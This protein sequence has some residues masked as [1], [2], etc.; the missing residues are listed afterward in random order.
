MTRTI[1]ADLLAEQKKVT[2]TPSLAM[3]IADNG[4]P[5][6][7]AH[8]SPTASGATQTTAAIVTDTAII[9]IQRKNGKLQAQRI[10]DP[11][12]LS[13][14]NSW[15][16]IP[17]T[18]D[19]FYPA[20]F[21]TGS[22]VVLVYQNR[23]TGADDKKVYWRTSATGSSWNTAAYLWTPA[24]YLNGLQVG[25]SGGSSWS[26]FFYVDGTPGVSDTKVAFRRYTGSGFAAADISGDIGAGI[27]GLGATLKTA[28]EYVVVVST[29]SYVS[30]A[31]NSLVALTFDGDLG[32]YITLG[33]F[34]DLQG[35][36]ASSPAY[37]ATKLNLYLRD[38]RYWLS[39]LMEV[40]QSKGAFLQKGDF[41]LTT[42]ET[43][44]YPAAGIKLGD[45]TRIGGEAVGDCVR[46]LY[47]PASG[48]TYLAADGV[49]LKSTPIAALSAD[50]TD[51]IQYRLEDDGPAGQLEIT[52]DNRTGSFD[53]L[54]TGRLGAD[55]TLSRGAVIN[56]TARRVSREKF[57]V[58]QIVWS[59]DNSR[60]TVRGYN[61]YRLL[62]LWRAEWDYYWQSQT[63]RGLV[64]ILTGLAGLTD[65]TFDA[66]FS[67]WST[68]VDEFSLQA[69]QSALNG[70]EILMSQF[71]F[72]ARMDETNRLACL[73]LSDS[74]TALYT[75]G[76]AGG[77][78]PTLFVQD[79]SERTLPDT[80]HALVLGDEVGGEALASAIQ[81]E[82][83]RRFT[84]FASRRY[85][86]TNSMAAATAGAIITKVEQSVKQARLICLPAFHLEPF[87]AVQA[88][89][90]ETD[91]IHYL[92]NLQEVYNT[93]GSV[94][95]WSQTLDLAAL[96]G[97]MT[98]KRGV[99]MP[100]GGR[101]IDARRG[102]VISFDL[103]TWQAI[104]VLDGSATGFALHVGCWVPAGLMVAGATVAVLLFDENNPADGV[105]LGPFG[106]PESLVTFAPGGELTIESGQITVTHSYHTVDTESNAASDDLTTINGGSEGDL[107]LIRAADDARTIVA[108]DGTGNLRLSSDFS[109]DH[110]AD[111][112]TLLRGSSFWWEISRSDNQ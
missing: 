50:E 81:S 33:S 52:L 101:R 99:A 19:M 68:T 93:T 94:R 97:T 63:V 111:T 58:S 89:G 110:S 78:H 46:P 8:L 27:R 17:N 65:W 18:T 16:A 15:T 44:Q 64:K 24:Y 32:A 4:L 90:F 14:W 84:R 49:V 88:D 47:W 25:V 108:K 74:P 2:Y 38:G 23:S 3:T 37:Q 36:D 96:S 69:G 41:Y 92:S 100:G 42:A 66:G 39:Y 28:G 80:T 26:G 70:L 77:E 87:D 30:W 10:T 51:I 48:D 112:L 106:S 60:V 86:T 83:G 43:I 9:R 98:G 107:L 85:I 109:L 55:L 22:A 12:S 71:Q 57:V 73:A 104:I 29:L 7:V 45:L 11:T 82:C 103:S 75:F 54:A 5:H 61:Y 20:L 91:Q 1:H 6:P 76:Q 95:P 31:T 72:V 62:Q 53:D 105:V 34:L 59:A 102:K 35:G 13:Q 79:S 40:Q 56:G 21:W 67:Y